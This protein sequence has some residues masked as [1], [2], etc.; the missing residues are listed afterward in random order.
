MTFTV[1]RANA[2]AGAFTVDYA[3]AN[4]TATA[5]SDYVA[6]SGTLSF[7]DNQ[8]SATV[9][10]T[11]NDDGIAEL[12]ETLFLN[13]SS[14]RAARPSPTARASARSSTTTA[15]RS[16]SRSTTSRSSRATAAPQNPDLHRHPH[17]RHRR[18]R[19]QFRDPGRHRIATRARAGL[20]RQQR[21]AQFRRRPEQPDDLGHRSTATLFPSRT[22]PSRSCCP[23]RP[24]T[25]IIIDGTG[26]GTIVN[27]E[28]TFIHDIQGTSYFS[29][30]LAGDGISAFNIASTTVVTVR[31]IVT[32]VDNVG[33]R[34]GYYL[35]EEITDWDGNSFTSEGI[36]VMTRNDAGVGTV[37][38]GVSVGD[39]VQLSASVMEYQAFSTMPRTVLVNSTGL[40]IISTGN[41][42]PTVT[43]TN[44]PNAVM[45]L[46][47]PG[48]HR[49][50]RRRR[51]YVRRLALRPLLLRDGRG[52]ARH[53]PQHGR[54]R[55]LR[56]D[57][58][59]RSLSPGLFARQRQC[60]P[61][62]QPRRL[63]DRRRSA[64]RPARHRRR[65]TTTPTMAA[66]CSMTATSIPTSSSST[67]PI[68]RS[69]APT[70][71]LENATMGDQL[72][73]VTGIIDF[74]FT[75]RKLFVTAMEPGGFV[76]GGNPVQETTVPRRR[77]PAASPSPPSTSRISIRAT[78]PR[79]SPRSPTRSP[80][81]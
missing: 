63:Y 23:A 19:R 81:I 55:R 53:H 3:T 17:R 22:R 52:H 56:A 73:D 31:A 59:R 2:A 58:G 33:P 5:G 6:T 45:T 40:S 67:S 48:L 30:I 34:Q 71:L 75:D 42:L 28:P 26:I 25:P 47:H 70:G 68:S 44:M 7:A 14:A 77:Q 74:D 76:D 54:G 51:R 4:G 1:T 37:V 62:Q 35:A 43:L 18:V 46:R 78:A 57:L 65:P 8:V 21:H 38:S 39:L 29:P 49:F 16:R 12:D 13:L 60:R 24:T 61:D 66:A 10:V 69:R 9:T 27:D 41:A 11:I 20:C 80:T 79:A 72:G 15:R 32:A 64:D 50:L 36:F